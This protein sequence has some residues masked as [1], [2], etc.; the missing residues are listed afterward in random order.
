MV[1]SKNQTGCAWLLAIAFGLAVLGQCSSVSGPSGTTNS[2]TTEPLNLSATTQD[3]KEGKSDFAPPSGESTKFIDGETVYVTANS[4]NGRSDPSGKGRVVSK[5]PQSTSVQIIE[6]SGNWMRVRA[7]KGDVWI[8]SDHVSRSRPARRPR[9]QPPNRSYGGNCPCN[10]RNVCI[11]PR[12]GRYCI[13]S[14]GNKR[15]GV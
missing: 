11:G 6:R 7:P 15:Y 4:L 3:L 10:G 5:I 9:Y 2:E 14:G 8:S 12:G 13:T 1:Q